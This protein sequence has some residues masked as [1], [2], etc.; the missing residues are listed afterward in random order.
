VG[1]I[2]IG[3]LI[4]GLL[5]LSYESQPT[6]PYR[7]QAHFDDLTPHDP[8]VINDNQDFETQAWPGNGSESNPFII[9]GFNITNFD[10]C[11]S[12]TGTTS[13]FIVRNCFLRSIGGYAGFAINLQDVSNG[14]IEDCT[15]A[16]FGIWGPEG[17]DF[18]TSGV[19]ANIQESKSCT[20]SGNNICNNGIGFRIDWSTD[21][22]V[23]DNLIYDN[24][25][26]MQIS[27]TNYSIFEEI[28]FF[29]NHEGIWFDNIDSCR[30][31]NQTISSDSVGMLVRFSRNL[32]LVDNSFIGCGI[33][34]WGTRDATDLNHTIEGNFANGRPIEYIFSRSDIMVNGENFSQIILAECN[35]VTLFD[36]SARNA[37][38]GIQLI[39]SIGCNVTNSSSKDNKWEGVYLLSCYDCVIMSNTVLRNIYGVRVEECEGVLIEK[40]AFHSNFRSVNVYESKQ[41]QIKENGIYNSSYCGIKIS[42]SNEMTLNLNSIFN[43]TFGIRV[44]YSNQILIKENIVYDCI[45]IG[46]DL[47]YETFLIRIYYNLLGWNTRNA[48]DDGSSNT[49][50]DG[51]D[52]GNNWTDYC[53]EGWYAISG[54]AGSY[55]RYP[56][57]LQDSDRPNVT[58]PACWNLVSTLVLIVCVVFGTGV[59]AFV[60]L[61][62]L[63][64]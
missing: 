12:I 55:D 56:S 17:G 54:E 50:D 36:V 15:L 5:V 59:V 21:L 1:I 22:E 32:T 33:R 7:L 9:E 38:V 43:S 14:T 57:F 40:N 53:G 31:V 60:I 44:L 28:Q 48:R 30:F 41:C 63:R 10:S 34:F 19:G 42:H 11:I 24:I 18:L 47:S 52:Q 64:S 62:K 29:A 25:Y 51:I 58:Q 23:H 39:R 45:E 4:T 16:S 49:W 35:N 26:G 2:V 46:I 27:N 13:H 8:I 37:T 3:Q 6:D 20:F 61:R